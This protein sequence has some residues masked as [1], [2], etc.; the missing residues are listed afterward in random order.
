MTKR[1]KGKLLLVDDDRDLLRLLSMRLAAAGYETVAVESGEEAL[2]RLEMAPFQVMVTDLRMEGMNGMALFEAVHQRNPT[3]PVIILTAHGTIPDAV[4]ATKRGVFAYL[5][6]PFDGQELIEQIARAISLTGVETKASTEEQDAQWRREIVTRSPLMEDLLGQT[7]LVAESQA[8][9]LIYGESGTGKE[10]LARAI[11]KASPRR[12]RPFVAFNCA[13]IPESLMESELFGYSKGAFTGALR[14]QP[15]LFQAAHGGTLFLDEIGDMP[16]LL[17]AKLLRAIQE[18]HVRPVGSTQSVAV[19]VRL[20]SATHRDLE[21][22]VAAGRFRED[23]YYR[24]VV[25]T[26]EIPPLEKRRED[27]TLLAAHFLCELSRAATKQQVQGF[28]PEALELLLSAPWPGNVRQLFNVVEQTFA[29][30][31]TPLIPASLVQKALREQPAE[32]PS[33]EEA[34]T[35]FEQ[36]YL[37]RLLKITNG[38]VSQAA[39]LARRG[40]TDFYKLMRRHRLNPAMFKSPK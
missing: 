17:Q 32:F 2:A 31:T 33:F 29:L 16:L 26:L 10:L 13:A 35:R 5:T 12:A 38:N 28:S 7:K 27:I 11:H 9:I 24:L 37:I 19:D 23:L 30:S 3:M 21:A 18:R 36:E 8:S 40:R 14:D 15:G 6:K 4:A 39:R 20:L 22:E 34:R 25:V 1:K